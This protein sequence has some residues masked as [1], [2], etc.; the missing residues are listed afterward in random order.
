MKK[1]I[2]MA[3][4]VVAA[5]CAHVNQNAFQQLDVGMSIE[6]VEGILGKP[7]SCSNEL[8]NRECIWRDGDREVR[9]SYINNKAVV[10]SSNGLQ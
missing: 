6:R 1:L 5:G 2:V 9:V 3:G 4:L 8:G 10:F 7:E